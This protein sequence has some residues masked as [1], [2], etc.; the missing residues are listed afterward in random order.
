MNL[1]T[2]SSLFCLLL[3]G[4]HGFVLFHREYDAK[5][6]YFITANGINDVMKAISTATDDESKNKTTA[7]AAAARR[8]YLLIRLQALQNKRGMIVGC[9]RQLRLL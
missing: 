9:G 3:F 1:L 4:Y 2:F 8:P 5:T 7:A 6:G